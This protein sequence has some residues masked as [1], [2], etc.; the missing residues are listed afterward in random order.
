MI[1]LEHF[2][3]ATRSS[4]ADAQVTVTADRKSASTR[5]GR[6]VRWFGRLRTGRNRETAERFVGALRATYG[7]EI[8]GIVGSTE[9]VSSALKRGKPLRA[10]QVAA[11][12]DH[13]DRLAVDFRRA[14]A[15][16]AA[17][18]GKP[19]NRSGPTRLQMKIEH[20]ANRMPLGWGAKGVASLVDEAHV[21][22]RLQQQITAFGQ[23]G[24]RLVTIED[25]N[26]ILDA[27]VGAAVTAAYRSARSGALEKLSFRDP[28]SMAAKAL[29]RAAEERNLPLRLERLEPG[30]VNGLTRKV[31]A[32]LEKLDAPSLADAAK[33]RSIAE[34]T[35]ADFVSR[36]AA[37]VAAVAS[38]PV[39]ENA[40]AALREQV[41]H[42]A[43]SP[44]A[45]AMLR[46]TGVP[47]PE[48]F[49]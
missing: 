15:R 3:H 28:G 29:A 19:V 2:I 49:D 6:L 7:A 46:E 23:G 4:R 37:A 36:R 20:E 5:T 33:L 24:E 43:L 31:Q 25:A 42:D 18:F 35:A 34:R 26:R 14:N 38:L 21:A 10:R 22:R 11:S 17:G 27:V 41:L 48:Q 30:V 44:G 45:I 13:A 40:K 12:I 39:D 32:A 47:L 8:A 16:I 1:N 9:G